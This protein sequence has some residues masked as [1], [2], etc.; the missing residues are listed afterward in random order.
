MK[1]ADPDFAPRHVQSHN[2]QIWCPGNRILKVSFQDVP[3][4][5]LQLETHRRQPNDLGK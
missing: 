1:R 5:M 3:E 4:R 2:Y